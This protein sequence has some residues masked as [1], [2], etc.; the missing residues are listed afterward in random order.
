MVK[1][2]TE[3]QSSQTS[4]YLIHRE[5]KL[6]RIKVGLQLQYLV[7]SNKTLIELHVQL[8]FLF[9]F[10]FRVKCHIVHLSAASALPSIVAA[11]EKGAPLTVETC[12]HYLS[13]NA[14]TVPNGNTLYK[15]CP[16]I[17]EKK[18]Q[19]NLTLLIIFYCL[20]ESFYVVCKVYTNTQLSV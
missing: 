16:P 17:R 1:T 20:Q 8:S 3:N 6:S 2:Q 4:L 7:T 5:I 10:Y 18:N 9:T 19:V 13:L 15:C 11:K 14:E 12:H